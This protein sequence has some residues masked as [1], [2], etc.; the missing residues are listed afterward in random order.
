M[1][2]KKEVL[3][4]MG[5]SERLWNSNLAGPDI[6]QPHLNLKSALISARGWSGVFLSLFPL[7]FKFTNLALIN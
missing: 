7:W 2:Y 4:Q 5:Y 6:E 3:T 1:G